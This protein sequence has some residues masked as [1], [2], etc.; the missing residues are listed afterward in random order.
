MHGHK[1]NFSVIPDEAKLK[2]RLWR[3]EFRN[4]LCG[5]KRFLHSQE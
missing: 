4:L 2:V 3:A 5:I 1:L